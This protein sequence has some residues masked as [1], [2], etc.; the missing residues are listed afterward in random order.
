MKPRALVAVLLVLVGL[1]VVA[2]PATAAPDPSV[3]V[4]RTTGLVDGSEVDVTGSGLTPGATVQVIQ[5]DEDISPNDYYREACPALKKD[6][7][8][9][10]GGTLSVRVKLV[11]LTYTRVYGADDPVYCRD[12][13]CRLILAWSVGDDPEAEGAYHSVVSEPLEFTGSTATITVSPSRN[14]SAK[15][16]VRVTGTAYGAEGRTIK[17]LQQGCYDLVQG[18]GCYGQLPVRWGKVKADGTYAVDYPAQRRLGGGEDCLDPEIL[19]ACLITTVVL[20]AQGRRDDSFGVSRLGEPSAPVTF[21]G[22]A[23]SPSTDLSADQIVTV[24]ANGAP[25]DTDLQ[26]VLCDYYAANPTN[27]GSCAA[28]V[29]ARSD[30]SGHVSQPVTLVD[31]IYHEWHD[32]EKT[33]VYCRDDRCRIFLVSLD[34]RAAGTVVFQSA[35]LEFLGSAATLAV[36]PTTNLPTTRWVTATGTALGAE[37]HKVQVVEQACFPGRSYE[38]CYGQLPVKWGTVKDDGTFRVTYP[39][40]R[41]LGDDAKTDCRSTGTAARCRISVIVLDAAGKH[42]DSYG[43]KHLGQPGK[44]ITFAATT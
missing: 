40:S 17:V 29:T 21:R 12:D 1:V 43:V 22:V 27:D 44:V 42:D 18:N 36:T 11:D 13:G 34:E 9:T 25:R 30:S 31:L 26:V 20:D 24:T 3:S 41:Y 10:S 14:L 2:P 8:V 38:P 19:G 16:T 6:V 32:G 15:K 35:P 5:C 37:G 39:A 33:A 7:V 28:L 23:V 4:S